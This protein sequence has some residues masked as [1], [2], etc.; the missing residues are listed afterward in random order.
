MYSPYHL[1]LS[2]AVQATGVDCPRVG[3]PDA[4][5]GRASAELK[6][7]TEKEGDDGDTP[8]ELGETIMSTYLPQ[9]TAIC[10]RRT[11]PFDSPYAVADRSAPNLECY[12]H[13]NLPG[14]TSPFAEESE[15]TAESVAQQRS[16]EKKE[17]VVSLELKNYRSTRVDVDRNGRRSLVN[18]MR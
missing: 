16:V 14:Q 10:S 5:S 6:V 8:L 7:P 1:A 13:G 12:L 11:H 4:T 18:E 15:A 9:V 17:N 2:G 3:S